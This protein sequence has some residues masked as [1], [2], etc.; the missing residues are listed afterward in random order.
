MFSFH[1]I[2]SVGK[3][4]SVKK[5]KVRK[6]GAMPEQETQSG[7]L[8]ENFPHRNGVLEPIP[9]LGEAKLGTLT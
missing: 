4:F 6:A 1:V 5:R 7:F 2:R 3:S 9:F 8:L